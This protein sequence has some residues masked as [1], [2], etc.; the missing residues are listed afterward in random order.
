MS[1]V[2]VRCS[3]DLASR[4]AL[5]AL[6]VLAAFAAVA[7]A[8]VL[9]P[10]TNAQLPPIGIR[11]DALP[12]WRELP[13][14]DGAAYI[15]RKSD[16]NGK[17]VATL[18][19]VIVESEKPGGSIADAGVAEGLE[20]ELLQVLPGGKVTERTPLDV[21]SFKAFRLTVEAMVGGKPTILRQT[22]VDIRRGVVTVT[23]L[24]DPAAAAK[25][26]P[27][28]DKMVAGMAIDAVIP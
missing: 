12:G 17:V 11:V 10:H 23:A 5:V 3:A 16:E 8:S 15:F 28:I 2:A 25:L 20:S 4:R 19:V 18:N 21:G 13:P 7:D 27:E 22:T 24:V 6:V 1:D 9:A 26:F 14:K